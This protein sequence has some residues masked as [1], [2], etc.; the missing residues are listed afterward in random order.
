MIIVSVPLHEL[1][2][3]MISK[4]LQGYIC[5]QRRRRRIYTK[6]I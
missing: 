5:G 3:V 6:D 1:D 2:R 4:R